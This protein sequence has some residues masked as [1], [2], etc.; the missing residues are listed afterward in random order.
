[1][2]H[3]LRLKEKS[4]QN[5][6]IRGQQFSILN[7]STRVHSHPFAT[8][9]R[10]FAVENVDWG[11]RTNLVVNSGSMIGEVFLVVELADGG[12]QN[13]CKNIGLAL[14]ENLIV[15]YA[16]REITNDNYGDRI[17]LTMQKL[18]NEETR[19][20]LLKLCGNYQNAGDNPG[21]VI[22][23]LPT[24]F[25]GLSR[26]WRTAAGWINSGSTKL[27]YEIQWATKASCSAGDAANQIVNVD[28]YFN[29]IYLPTAMEK[30]VVA[31][32][33]SRK[34]NDFATMEFAIVAGTEIECDIS[35]LLASGHLKTLWMKESSAAAVGVSK[36]VLEV[37]RGSTFEIKLNSKELCNYDDQVLLDISQLLQ[38]FRYDRVRDTPFAF[39]FAALPSRDNV[40]GFLASQNSH[41]VCKYTPKVT[42]K[43]TIIAENIKKLSKTPSGRLTKSD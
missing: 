11:N 42:G 9:L 7:E 31:A 6:G 12:G 10:H 38:R 1:M 4:G 3:I 23:Y 16:A 37:Q 26:D 35:A 8:A 27:E 30:N 15:R 2:E 39:S 25:S 32:N 43:L 14:I 13:Y 34:I 36:D 5:L 21:K 22:V 41:L 29:E 24:F 28:C 33:R 19:E 20:E 17:W 18:Q 40:D